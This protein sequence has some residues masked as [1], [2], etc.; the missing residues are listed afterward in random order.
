MNF[1]VTLHIGSYALTLHALLETAAFFLGFR[2]FLYLRR[3]QGDAFATQS[4][5]WIVL[6]AIVGS[7]LGSHL[8]GSLERPYELAMSKNLLLYVAGNKTVL[9][10]FLGGLL[11]VELTKM[12]IGEQRASGDLFV[13]PMILALIVGRIGCFSMG[14]YEETYGI[15]TDSFFGMNLG[16]GIPRHPAALYEIAFLLL[17]GIAIRSTA[18]RFALAEGAL[19]KLF[20]IAYCAFRFGLDFLKPHTPVLFRLST[21]QLTALAGLLYYLPYLLR[22]KKLT[23]VYA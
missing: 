6:G 17:L 18:R 14:I 21:I 15:Y 4:R 19:F 9:G 11:G 8:I 7:L 16:D 3:R 20:L 23:A 12:I 5:A 13:Y 2:Y 10:G 1:P 22:P